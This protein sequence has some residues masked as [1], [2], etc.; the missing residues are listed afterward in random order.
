MSV[1]PK[2]YIDELRQRLTLSE[3]IGKRIKVTR[4]G[5]EFKA[6]CPFHNE[7]TPSFTINDQKGFY[8]CFGCGAHGDVVG[9]VMQHDNLAF[10]DAVEQLSAQAGL[11][12]PKATPEERQKFE[13]QKTLYDVIEAGCK[14][15]EAQLWLPAN[16]FALDYLLNRGLTEKT[17]RDFRIG[18]APDDHNLFVQDMKAQNQDMVQLREVGLTRASKK[19]GQDDY[20]FF[21]GRI[22]FPVT[23]KRG[24]VIAFGGRILPQYD[25][26]N[27][28]Y[29]PAKYMNSPD[30]DLFHKGTILY[31][32][33][34][35]RQAASQKNEPIIVT[36][37]YMD[38][39]ALAQA[40]IETGVAPLGTALTESQIV[41]TWKI[42]PYD[43]KYP[44]LCFDGDNAGYR[45]AFRAVERMM[46]ML[47][48]EQSAKFVFMP[49]GEDPDSLIKKGGRRAFDALLEG[50]LPLFKAL[51]MKET[52]GRSLDTP[53]DK[54][55]LKN[56]LMEMVFKIEN[57]DVQSFYARQVNDEIYHTF[58][59]RFNKGGFGKKQAG[60]TA[61][62]A[63]LVNKKDEI[64]SRILL[65]TMINHTE[66]LADQMDVIFSLPMASDSL[67]KLRD[68]MLHL[69][70]ENEE[71][72][73]NEK[74]KLK[75]AL[76]DAGHE[77]T[78]DVLL[79]NNTYLHAPFAKTDAEVE[80]ILNGWKNT[81]ELF[82]KDG[83]VLDLRK[84]VADWQSANNDDDEKKIS[85]RLKSLG[86]II[87]AQEDNDY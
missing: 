31:N 80:D 19:Q 77:K 68:D 52:E 65:A 4:A 67:L 60:P 55:G 36:E 35:A 34:K 7:N 2:N 12:M 71:R 76:I 28:D 61:K 17:I 87:L 29:T 9:F 58:R 63:Q 47:G 27:G 57:K 82:Q 16:R 26:K 8:H 38:V 40:G 50:A 44:Y 24:R 39:I 32:M 21:R 54:A 51:W 20:A 14:W 3:I 73:E 78:L 6:C 25:V 13:K 64:R 69:Y 37:G 33:S 75:S 49:Q 59:P 72:G 85:S 11:E 46:P 18:F 84:T 30:H 86:H 1:I 66:L 79:S 53:E 42:S 43:N 48:P 22:M 23:D 41:E 56:R 62:V 10:M 70:Y 5:R 74:N 45:A 81:L 83:V 15:F